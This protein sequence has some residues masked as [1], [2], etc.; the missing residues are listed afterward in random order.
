M[1]E[2]GEDVQATTTTKNNYG[3]ETVAIIKAEIIYNDTLPFLKYPAHIGINMELDIGRDFFP[4]MYLGG[5]Y[6][7]DPAT[8][9]I[10]G[11]S[12]NKAVD[13]LLRSIGMPI[14]CPKGQTV[15]SALLPAETADKMV[16]RKFTKL[17]YLSST[18][19][20]KDGTPRW[21]DFN[22]TVKPGDDAQLVK[23]F[24]HAVKNNFVKDYAE[25]GHQHPLTDSVIEKF[26]GELMDDGLPV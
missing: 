18:R 8:E 14:K 2:F 21:V 20:K 16:G 12:T 4:S 11:W 6:K 26:D 9:E 24:L 3:T 19:T 13:F 25:P 1:I 23:Q 17:K 10:I 22:N 15:T 7:L 5:N